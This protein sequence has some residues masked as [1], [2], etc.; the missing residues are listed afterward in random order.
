LIIAS[1]ISPWLRRV[2]REEEVWIGVGERLTCVEAGVLDA[3][4]MGKTRLER[5]CTRTI[6]ALSVVRNPRAWELVE[7]HLH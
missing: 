6:A 3:R 7:R 1:S 4:S 5:S 2:V